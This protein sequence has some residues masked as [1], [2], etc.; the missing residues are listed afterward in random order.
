MQLNDDKLKAVLSKN[1]KFARATSELTQE[2]LSED[3]HISLSFLRDIESA[4]SSGSILTLISLCQALNT[5]PNQILK[6]FFKDSTSKSNDIEH[7]LNLLSDY[8]KDAILT[9]IN[10]Y[11]SNE[12]D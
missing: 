10:F 5:T 8:Q 12:S 6:D 2:A 1:I 3:A 11:I 4:K 7:K 9:L